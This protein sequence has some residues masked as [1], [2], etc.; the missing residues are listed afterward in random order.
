M[1]L[2]REEGNEGERREI[3]GQRNTAA[4]LIIAYESFMGRS[5]RH[6]DPQQQVRLPWC[7]RIYLPVS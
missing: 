2:R 4:A 3:N 7:L 5:R 1:R 6:Q